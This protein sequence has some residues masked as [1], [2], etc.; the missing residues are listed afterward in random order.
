MIQVASFGTLASLNEKRK[1]KN[2]KQVCCRFYLKKWKQVLNLPPGFREFPFS[3][4]SFMLLKDRFGVDSIYT[5]MEAS[6]KL[7][8]EISLPP[9]SFI[10][11]WY[12]HRSKVLKNVIVYDHQIFG[13]EILS[14]CPMF[15]F[16]LF[17]L[18]R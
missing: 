7:A 15:S 3:P 8:S 10:W 16:V 9:C 6:F 18:Q 17:G 13:Y 4:F 12:F 14:G 5:R 1:T 11:I 2:E